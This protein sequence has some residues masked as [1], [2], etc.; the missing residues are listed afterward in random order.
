MTGLSGCL[1]CAVPDPLCHVISW[2]LCGGTSVLSNHLSGPNLH[3]LEHQECNLMCIWKLPVTLEA[4]SY[5]VLHL[6]QKKILNIKHCLLHQG[7]EELKLEASQAL[8]VSHPG[9]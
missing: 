7:I 5:R 4:L 2:K 8:L 9:K 1:W 6:R 3:R